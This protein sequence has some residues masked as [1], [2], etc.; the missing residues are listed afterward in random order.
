MKGFL[1]HPAEWGSGPSLCGFSERSP[2]DSVF[3]VRAFLSLAIVALLW[4]AGASALR[5]AQ[6]PVGREPADFDSELEQARGRGA[7]LFQIHCAACHGLEGHGDGP[8]A[9][10]LKT[11]PADLTELSRPRSDDSGTLDFPSARLEAVIDGRE[12]LRGHGT[13][14]MPI[15]G[16][17]FQEPGRDGDQEELVRRKIDDL[18][19]Y[20]RTIQEPLE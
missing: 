4:V 15:W 10:D 7:L 1:Y 19:E 20:L 6:E 2:A 8:L 11:A 14:E 12:E 17:T 9:R 13:R 5:A 3:Q 18:L 16:L